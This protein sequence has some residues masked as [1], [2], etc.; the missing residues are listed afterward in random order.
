MWVGRKDAAV[1]GQKRCLCSPIAK[2]KLA[3]TKSRVS[4]ENGMRTEGGLPTGSSGSRG[5]CGMFSIR[6][7][8]S[9]VVS[10]RSPGIEVSCSGMVSVLVQ[11]MKFCGTRGEGLLVGD[12]D[13]KPVT[14]TDFRSKSLPR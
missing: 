6:T 13:R 12:L 2:T 3:E 8:G 1:G 9:V 14:T 5:G 4:K 7:E 10:L 11:A